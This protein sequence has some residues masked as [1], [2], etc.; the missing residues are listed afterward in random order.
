MKIISLVSILRA[1]AN[2]LNDKADQIALNEK[3]KNTKFK[4]RVYNESC[5]CDNGQTPASLVGCFCN[6]WKENVKI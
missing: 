4:D 2:F 6:C 1:I 3:I 5:N